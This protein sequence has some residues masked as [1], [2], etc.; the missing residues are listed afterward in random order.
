M[1]TAFPP[2]PQLE[3]R[4][5]PVTVARVPCDTT[6]Y[7]VSTANASATVTYAAAGLKL[8]HKVEYA[9]IS[10]VSGT[11]ISNFTITDAVL[12]AV[13]FDLDLPAPGVYTI[14][15]GWKG[16]S[17]NGAVAFSIGAGGSGVIG[18]INI[19]GHKMESC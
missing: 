15:L 8:A 18:K 19:V 10:L 9:I 14:P 11:G 1:S 5:M 7:A 16:F 3:I 12:A 4:A 17:Q 2:I 13:V 6:D